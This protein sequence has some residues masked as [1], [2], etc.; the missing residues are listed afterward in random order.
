MRIMFFDHPTRQ[1]RSI[2]SLVIVAS[3]W[4]ATIGNLVLWRNLIALPDLSGWHKGLFVCAFALIIASVVTF[5]LS[6][7]AWRYTLKPL[8]SLLLLLTGISTHYMWMYGIVVDTPMVVNVFQTDV[9]EARDQMSWQLMLTVTALAGLPL[10]WLWRQ[11]IKPAPFKQQLQRNMVLFVGSALLAFVSLQLVFQDFASLMRNHTQL[12]YQINPLNSIYALLDLTVIPSDK[13]QGPLQP[14]GQDA[15]IDRLD[16]KPDQRPPLLV[17]VLGETARSQNFSL[18]GYAKQTNPLLAKENVTSF[19]NVASCG[20]STAESVP[21]MFSHLG[22]SEFKNRN[23]EFE[24]LLDVLQRAGYAVLW[25]DNQSG[26]KDQCDRIP[27]INTSD[28]NVPEHC[29]GGECRDTVMLTRIEAELAKLPAE[30]RTRGTVVVMH[31]MGSHGPA[32]FKRTPAEFKPFKPECTDTS[33]SQCDRAQ[34]VNAYDNTIVFTD[35][36]LSRVIAWLK[37]QEKT[38]TPAMLYVSDH[39]ESLGEKNMYLHGLPYSVAP[40][41][42]TTVPMITWLSPGF[43]Q[44]SRVSTRCLQNQRDKPLSHDN[45]FHSVLG[46]MAVKTSVYQRELDFFATCEGR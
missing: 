8:I 15:H 42:Q 23:A 26:C 4:L 11:T 32:Y 22:R 19:R 43:E 6:L 46:L 9:R 25:I 13:P 40:P 36:F 7:L 35:Y 5:L 31:Q 34:V 21:C 29:E 14:I 38:H 2:L 27:N 28:L 1:P 41:E 12:R 10:I 20:T 33:L 24:N 39:G 45:L 3:T 30:R 16:G 18:N 44:L 37:S 17:F